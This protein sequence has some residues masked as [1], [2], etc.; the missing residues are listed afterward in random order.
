MIMDEIVSLL[1]NFGF[2]VAVTIILLWD[3]LR[4]QDKFNTLVENNTIAMTRVC[5]VIHKCQKV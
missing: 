3:K 5:D 2:P 4:S 1:Q